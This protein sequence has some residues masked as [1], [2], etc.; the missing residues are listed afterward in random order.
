MVLQRRTI[1]NGHLLLPVQRVDVSGVTLF[2]KRPFQTCLKTR[3]DDFTVFKGWEDLFDQ[4]QSFIITAFEYGSKADHTTQPR[5]AGRLFT[6][7]N[8]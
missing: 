6:V 4:C 2:L 5:I 3:R 8:P 7:A 1:L